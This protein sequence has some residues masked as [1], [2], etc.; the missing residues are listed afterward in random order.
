[1]GTELVVAFGPSGPPGWD[2][3]RAALRA[4]GRAAE[5][6]MI[7]GLPA[8]PDEEPP[9]DWRELRVTLGNG[10]VTVRRDGAA[11]RCV[12]WGNADEALRRDWEAVAWACAVAGGGTIRLPDGEFDAVAFRAARGIEPAG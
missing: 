4:D 5:L 9:V 3:V 12:V 7:D 1:M 8:F 2:A 6:R 11:L 10:M